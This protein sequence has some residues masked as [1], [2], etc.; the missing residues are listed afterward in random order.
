MAVVDAVMGWLSEMST[1]KAGV[2]MLAIVLLGLLGGTAV[3]VVVAMCR[4]WHK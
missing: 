4:G 1:V 3:V 2:T